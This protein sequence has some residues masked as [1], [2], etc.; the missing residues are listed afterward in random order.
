MRE[1]VIAGSGAPTV[2]APELVAS[3]LRQLIDRP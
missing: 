1:K 2:S 3:V